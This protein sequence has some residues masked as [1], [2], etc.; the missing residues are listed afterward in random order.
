MPNTSYGQILATVSDHRN[1]D[2]LIASLR[3]DF[4][5]MFPDAQIMLKKFVRGPGTGGKIEARFQGPDT[6]VLRTLSEQAQAIM[7]TDP[8]AVEIHD[9]WRQQILVLRPQVAEATAR[10]MGITRPQIADALAMNFSG[11][12]IGLYREGNRLIP[13]MVQAPEN[14]R[15]AANQIDNITL[16]SPLSGSAAPLRQLVTEVQTEWEDSIIRRENRIRTITA[17]CNPLYGN[18][19]VLF[20]RLRPQIEAMELPRGYELKWGGEYES[21]SDAQAGLMQMM[22]LFFLAMVFTVM[23]LFNAVRQTIIIFLCLPLAAI[24]VAAGLLFFQEPF[25]FMCLLGFIGLSGML[26]KNAVV[27]IDQ[28]DLEIREGKEPYTAVLD[29]SVSRLRPVTMAALTTVLGMLPLLSD[30][31]FV[32]MSV[33]IMGGLTFGTVLTLVVVPV[34]YSSFF[35]IRRVA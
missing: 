6:V 34:L 26:I 16:F 21:S 15:G 7:A 28:I 30:V 27:L 20:N 3:K 5:D 22:P 13:M 25:G 19:S 11:K 8:V 12:T 10:R 35:R 31:F 33:T 9:D 32:G 23:I 17:K 4:A 18:A 1:I 14:E 29:S 24:G 2:G